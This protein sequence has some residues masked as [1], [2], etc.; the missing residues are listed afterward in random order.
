MLWLLIKVQEH[1]GHGSGGA[2]CLSSLV[3]S[4]SR[5]RGSQNAPRTNQVSPHQ[6]LV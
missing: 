6:L 4:R 3:C 5:W 1:E 2:E